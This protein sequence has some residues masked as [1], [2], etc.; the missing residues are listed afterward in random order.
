M[1]TGDHPQTASSIAKD[2]GIIPRNPGALPASVAEHLVKT[3]SEIDGMSDEEIDQLP[4]LP[5][6]I[7]RCAPETKT[8]MIRAIHRY[9]SICM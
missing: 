4:A 3:A 9:V 7:A 2:V 6:V 8:K 5:L 1:L